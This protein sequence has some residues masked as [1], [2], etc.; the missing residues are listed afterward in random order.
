MNEPTLIDCPMCNEQFKLCTISFS[1]FRFCYVAISGCP[2]KHTY[3]S[4]PYKK[5]VYRKGKWKLVKIYYL[6]SSA[7][8]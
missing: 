3:E 1:L 8:D 2:G 5:E 7:W 4:T 6:L